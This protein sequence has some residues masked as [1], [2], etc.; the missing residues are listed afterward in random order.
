ML[1]QLSKPPVLANASAAW[2]DTVACKDTKVGYE[3]NKQK[4]V[5]AVATEVIFRPLQGEEHAVG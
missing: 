1:A 5:T 2:A 3:Q 4:A